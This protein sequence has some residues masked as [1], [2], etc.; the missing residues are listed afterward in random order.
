VIE[1]DLATPFTA[2]RARNAGIAKLVED[3]DR[4]VDFAQV[5]DGDCELAPGFIEAALETMFA[6]RARPSSAVGVA[7]VARI[8]RST[9]PSATSSGT[10]PIGEIDAC[11]GDALLRVAAFREVGDTIPA[12]LPARTGAVPSFATS[13]NGRHAASITR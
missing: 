5:V 12:S 4:P 13:R 3:A 6:T 11:G 2:A 7:N 10:R 9:T 1:L 8:D